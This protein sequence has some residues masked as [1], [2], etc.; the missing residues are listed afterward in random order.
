METAL[1]SLAPEH[2]SAT[3]AVGQVRQREAPAHTVPTETD[4][5]DQRPF[6]LPQTRRKRGRRSRNT[7]AAR[8]VATPAVSDAVVTPPRTNEDSVPP[9]RALG[10]SQTADPGS[11]GAADYAPYNSV[12][13]RDDAAAH[14]A[15]HRRP[16]RLNFTA[17]AQCAVA[18]EGFAAVPAAA[19]CV[20]S[21]AVPVPSG[22]ASSP[23]LSAAIQQ[24]RSLVGRPQVFTRDGIAIT[25][26]SSVAVLT[27]GR[28]TD[29]RLL[30]ADGLRELVHAAHA[31]LISHERVTSPFPIF[32]V[33]GVP[34]VAKGSAILVYPDAASARLTQCLA[35]LFASAAGFQCLDLSSVDGRVALANYCDDEAEAAARCLE[36]AADGCV[37]GLDNRFRIL[38]HQARQRLSCMGLA[39]SLRAHHSASAKVREDFAKSKAKQDSIF[40]ALTAAA[41][42]VKD[43]AV[44]AATGVTV[45]SP[46]AATGAASGR[47]GAAKC[48]IRRPRGTAGSKV[49]KPLT[50]AHAAPGG[51]V[52]PPDVVAPPGQAESSLAVPASVACAEAAAPVDAMG[53]NTRAVTSATIVAESQDAGNGEENVS[54]RDAGAPAAIRVEEYE[55]RA[56]ERID[57]ETCRGASDMEVEAVVEAEPAGAR[58][59]DGGQCAATLGTGIEP[60]VP[61]PAPS[62]HGIPASLPATAPHI[63]GATPYVPL[64]S[65]FAFSALRA[66]A[67]R[68]N[69]TADEDGNSRSVVYD[70]SG[71]YWAAVPIT[72]LLSDDESAIERVGDACSTDASASAAG[73]ISSDTVGLTLAIDAQ[74]AGAGI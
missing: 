30:A 35:L 68:G 1:A 4:D 58:A 50:T 70:A 72:Q 31:E 38:P 24:S 40:A 29:G 13:E 52:A 36:R 3:A 9:S 23:R 15:A 51:T 62:R 53:G 74:L 14:L 47:R 73:A 10:A 54:A 27:C 33:V 18:K 46:H 66:E 65:A 56:I 25:Q 11:A 45:D 26:Q 44:A 60:S 37:N 20:W 19:R 2:V 59:C 55:M 32:T 42:A 16:Q 49:R 34:E 28:S 21:R 71:R 67:V 5:P 12:T 7:P 69:T 64:G 48:L 8:N 43:P 41:A 22:V 57:D 6:V 63:P 39:E 17:A 61:A